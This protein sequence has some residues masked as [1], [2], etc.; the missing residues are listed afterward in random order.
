MHAV[1]RHG[2][3]LH[4]VRWVMVMVGRRREPYKNG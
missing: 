1:Q 3:S 2:L 4:M